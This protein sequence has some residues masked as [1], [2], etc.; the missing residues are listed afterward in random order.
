LSVGRFT[1]AQSFISLLKS[2]NGE[3]ALS[4]LREA[5]CL[6]VVRRANEYCPASARRVSH[7][8]GKPLET[9]LNP[10]KT[11]VV[12]VRRLVLIMNTFIVF[13]A[14]S[15]NWQRYIRYGVFT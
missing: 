7:L 10:V 14:A 5:W 15:L 3:Q 6:R 13:H 8:P 4:G 1:S 9:R 11:F 12:T 2:S